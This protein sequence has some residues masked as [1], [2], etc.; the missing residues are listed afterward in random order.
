[1]RRAGEHASPRACKIGLRGRD[2]QARATAPM[3]PRRS[4]DVDQAQVHAAPGVRDRRLYRPARAARTGFG[5]PAAGR[6]RRRGQPRLRRQGRHRLQRDACCASICGA[7]EA[8]S[9]IDQAPVPRPPAQRGPAHWVKPKLVAEVTFSEWTSE[10]HV[11]H[12]VFHGAARG[13]GP[14][15][16]S[17]A[18]RPEP[19]GGE[20]RSRRRQAVRKRPRRRG[21]HAPATQASRTPTARHRSVHRRRPSSTWCAT[22][23]LVAPLMHAPPRRAGRSS[24]VRAPDGRRRRAVLPE[25]HRERPASPAS[26]S[27]T[28]SCGPAH[29][30]HAGG[31]QPRGSLLAAAQMNVGRVSHLERAVKP[32]IDAAR[33]RDLRPRPRRGRRLGRSLRGARELTQAGSSS[34]AGP[35]Q[36]PQDQRRQGPARG[37]AAAPHVRLGPR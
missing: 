11:R 13:Q 8:R 23:S 4:P 34:A 29:P 27:S 20:R 16:R 12:P 33:P 14:G 24:L 21:G 30:P 32:R 26:A 2:R 7:A 15:R 25:A 37:G 36:L 3:R 35:A 19:R 9:S 1:M 17:C 22:T 28:P 31:R 5:S 10:G 18:R 6:A